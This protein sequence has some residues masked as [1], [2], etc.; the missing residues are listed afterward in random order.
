MF[1]Q[2]FKI[3][4]R[5]IGEGCK[6]YIIAEMS[7]NHGNDLNKAIEIVR[8]AKGCG[9]DAIKIQ[10][11]TADTLTLDCKD[12]AFEAKGAWEGVY[13]YDLYSE[14]SMPWE[15]TEILQKVADEEGIT[16]FSSPFDF[17]SIDF[18]EKLNMPAYKI[19]S[20]EMI[21][22]PFV[23]R[24]AQTG[25][26]I[27]MSTGNA[28]LE[29]IKEAVAVMVEEKVEDFAILKC[30]SEY[31]ASPSKINL[32]T[33][34]NLK[35]TFECVAGLSDHTLGSA[36][37]IASVGLGASIIEKHFIVSREDTTADSFFSATPDELK[38]I[39][40]GAKMV[41]EAVGDVSYPV[42]NEVQRSLIAIQEIKQG[43]A[44]VD[45]ENFKSL[46]PGGGIEPKYLD[47]VNK[48]K[49][50]RDIKVGAL[51]SWDLVG[52]SV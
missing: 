43:E 30:T 51:L 32:K 5:S 44:L 7:A 52:E 38:A 18:L 45:G 9:A 1:K 23:R 39:V 13:L 22:L 3:N 37:P 28:T 11:Y 33:I 50:T 8:K 19:A 35:D 14:A 47:D 40:E 49:A 42:A 12:K 4:G 16:L 15:W 25:K 36:I 20:P 26:P 10:T 17:S 21:D 48:R 27:I 2:K 31:P 6:P 46:R 41:Y 34:Q 29:Q 24:V